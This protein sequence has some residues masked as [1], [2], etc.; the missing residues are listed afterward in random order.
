M[1]LRYPL[2]WLVLVSALTITGL[3]AFWMSTVERSDA[4]ARFEQLVNGRI[5][6]LQ[7]SF[8]HFEIYLRGMNG[9]FASST[10]VAP[11]EWA[12]YIDSLELKLRREQFL[13][14]GYAPVVARADLPRFLAA[15]RIDRPDFRLPAQSAG[16]ER[17]AP[18]LLHE[19]MR[20]AVWPQLGDDLLA[21]S[22]SAEAFA[23]A[24]RSGKTVLVRRSATAD[25]SAGTMMILPL[26]R[27]ARSVGIAY[28][29]FGIDEIVGSAGLAGTPGIRSTIRDDSPGGGHLYGE[30]ASGASPATFASVRTLESGESRW[31]VRFESTPALEEQ[32]G[33]PMASAIALF[34]A[35]GSFLIFFLVRLLSGTRQR[36]EQIAERTTR[37]LSDQMKLTE[38]LI[39]LNP[40]PIFRKDAE[41]RFLQFNRAWERLTG[42]DRRDWMGKTVF[43]LLDHAEAERAT[44][45]E[46]ELALLPDKVERVETTLTTLDGAN[47]D[48]IIDMA[49]VRL[50]DGSFAGIIGTITDLTETRRLTTQNDAQREQL[51][52]VNQSAQAG[53]WDIELPQGKAYFSPRYYEMLGYAQIPDGGLAGARSELVHPDDRARVEVAREAHFSGSQPY[54][55]CEYRLR[56][57]D[58]SYLWVDGRGLASLDGEGKPV[59]FTGSIIDIAQRRVAQL[60]IERQ[61]EQLELVIESVQA[62]IWDENLISGECYF[63]QRYRDI[64]GLSAD[65]DLGAHLRDTDCYHPDDREGALAARDAAIR[66]GEPFDLE[67]RLH[68]GD[69]TYVWVNARAKASHDGAGAAVRYTG[70]IIDITTRK[71]AELELREANLRV[72]EAAQVKST[73]LATMSHE[74]R[75]PLNGVIGSAGLL[76]DTRLTPEQLDYV[77]TIRLS[78]VQLLTLIDDILDYSKIESGRMGLEDEPFDLATVIEDAFDMVGERARAKRLELIYDIA[79]DVPRR[80]HGDITRVRQ[81]LI[82]LVGNAVKFTD[83]GDVYVNCSLVAGDPAARDEL[84]LRMSVRD[85]GIGIAE[86]KL[87]RLF[88]PFTQVDASTTRKYGGTGLGL[89]ISQRLVGL[90]GGAVRVDSTAG[91]GST[92]EFTFKTRRATDDASLKRRQ[93]EI[94]SIEGKRVLIVDDYALNRRILAA[95]CATWGLMTAETASVREAIAAIA[96]A[97][98]SGTTFDAVISDMLMPGEDGIDLACQ[99]AAHRERHQV[100]LPVLILSSV[101]RAEAVAGRDVPEGWI[102]AYLLKPARESLMFN[103]LLDALAPE[104][105]FHLTGPESV[106]RPGATQVISRELRILLAEDNE[107][108]QKIALRMLERLGKSAALADNGRKAVEMVA[109]GEFDCLLMDVQMPE[110]DGL[111]ATRRIVANCAPGRAPYIIAMTANAMAGDREVCLAAGMH[112]YIA[113]PVQMR[114]LAEALVRAQQYLARRET[115]APAD[116]SAT[117][118]STI[119]A[120]SVEAAAARPAAPSGALDLSQIDELLGLDDS[121]EVLADF[122][123]MYTTQAPQRIAEIARSFEDGD[124][125]AVTRVAHSLKGASGNLGAVE[126]ADVARRIENACQAGTPEAVDAMIDEMRARYAEAEIALKALP[127]A[128]A[129]I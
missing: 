7:A 73:F 50:A 85:T 22:A 56:R 77:E 92:F 27:G 107:I 96:A 36:A 98:D 123:H 41:G 79:P 81:V 33:G 6:R 129:S 55:D 1:R 32:L 8:D 11:R 127:R 2:S 29:L 124:Y 24:E 74:I 75:T 21:D 23:R 94:G 113:K 65:E 126:V 109:E 119:C 84:M 83:K 121:G 82:N 47:C 13:S 20:A 25:A 93:G 53:V 95:Q 54:F 52:L 78:G 69:G 64:L 3:S 89:A 26:K 117:P 51:A 80:I 42:R 104:R 57:A 111:E 71:E 76:E 102:S 44:A 106:T 10:H 58:G 86:D 59:R 103:A 40:T 37:A 15:A 46:K 67:L 116:A 62:G 114:V 66:N 39:E 70:A 120:S 4:S 34:G 122:I 5:A 90:M 18:V 125:L 14:L 128:P 48:V 49:T 68:R 91:A 97:S 105:P 35:L 88:T 31:T 99:V 12:T 17:L 28:L 101:P 9:L 38:D 61:R 118:A 30:R 110:L 87:A 16:G 112:D 100:R 72:L 108:N 60:E 43:D 115:A 19:S 45:Q 63:S